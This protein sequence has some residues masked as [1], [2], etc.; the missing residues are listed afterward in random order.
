MKHFYK[1]LPKPGTPHAKKCM[2]RIKE[3]LE[4]KAPFSYDNNGRITVDVDQLV[5]S[6]GFKRQVAA[7]KELMRPEREPG[8]DDEEIKEER[9]DAM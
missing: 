9:D 5:Q 7:A 6:E 8:Q 3:M 1:L 2:E 4:G